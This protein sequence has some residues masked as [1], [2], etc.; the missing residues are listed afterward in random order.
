MKNS[1]RIAA[2]S[3]IF[4]ACI[5]SAA[6]GQKPAVQS[7][8]W[9]AKLNQML[10]LLGHRNWILIVDSAY[11]LQNSTGIETVGTGASQLEV[12]R[13]TLNAIE[14]SIHVRPIVYMDAELPFV[15]ENDAPGVSRYR[16]E[17]KAV[18]GDRRI[19]SLPHEQLL[20]KVEE[21]SKSFQVLILKTNEA[22]PYTSV[23]LQLDCK[24]WSAAAEARLREAMNHGT[25]PSQ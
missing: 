2:L 14:H 12:T 9:K 4:S 15:P 16:S 10:P 13:D 21:T 19:N 18:L 22:I 23:F 3:A 8:N 6:Y 11:P 5:L 7:S 17:I 25:A 24:Y 1:Y 20:Q